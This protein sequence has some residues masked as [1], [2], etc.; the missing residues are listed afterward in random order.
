MQ[1]LAK[2]LQIFK[3]ELRE[4]VHQQSEKILKQNE[5]IVQQKEI[6]NKQSETIT[7]LT[8]GT[9]VLFNCHKTPRIDYHLE[10]PNCN[11]NHHAKIK[12]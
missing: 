9:T 6:T 3:D 1:A 10:A 2:D 5:A 4:T 7:K 11:C 8:E 12:E